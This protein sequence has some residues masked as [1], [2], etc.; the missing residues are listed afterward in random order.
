[1]PPEEYDQVVTS[2]KFADIRVEKTLPWPDGRPGFYFVRLRYSDMADQIFAEEEAARRRPVEETAVINGETVQV[3]HSRFDGG[4]LPDLFDGDTFTLVR[5]QAANPVLLELTFPTPHRFTGVTLT[6][7]SFD[8][9]LIVRL[10]ADEDA[11]PVVYQQS[12]FGLPPDPTV[13]LTFENPPDQVMKVR[14]EIRSIN[15]AETAKVHVR[16]VTLH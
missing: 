15:D 12:Y 14:F 1:M 16:E 5:T 2:P 7:G 13:E 9:D 4:S 10:Y 3:L 11:E 6:T 8:I